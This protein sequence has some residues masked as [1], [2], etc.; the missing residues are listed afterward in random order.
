LR[1]PVVVACLS[2]FTATAVGMLGGAPALAATDGFVL[3]VGSAGPD[4]STLQQD[5]RTLGYFPSDE[6]IT[7]YFGPITRKAVIAFEQDR[8]LKLSDSVDSAL[9][10]LI[11]TAAD[12]S[13]TLPRKDA[14]QNS[15]GSLGQQIAQKALSYLGTPYVWGGDTPSGFD[16]SGLTR[17]V[18]GL[19]G[20]TLASTAA[21]QAQQG[22][23]VSKEDLEPGDLVFFDTTGGI[24]HVGIY[25]GDGKFVDAASTDVEIDSLNDPYYWASRYVT[26]RR[27][28]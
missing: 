16:C 19:F 22:Q 12:K 25:I 6:G 26:A 2:F 10:R 27:I 13:H 23:Y 20:I 1:F 9:M 17:Y 21:A 28:V 8:G 7:N 11:K 3:T 4:V 24:S 14:V 18:Y 15:N 5:L